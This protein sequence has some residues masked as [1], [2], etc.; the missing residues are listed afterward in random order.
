MGLV[1]LAMAKVE[2][3]NYLKGQGTSVLLIQISCLY[4]FQRLQFIL[5]SKDIGQVTSD[6]Y[7]MYPLTEPIIK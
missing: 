3:W 6:E 4:V 5:L 2:T 1:F 7:A